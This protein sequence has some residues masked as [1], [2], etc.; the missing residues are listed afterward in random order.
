LLDAILINAIGAF[1]NTQNDQA[2]CLKFNE[3]P[4]YIRIVL[5]ISSASIFTLLRAGTDIQFE[6]LPPEGEGRRLLSSEFGLLS[7]R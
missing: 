7:S 1:R 3:R 5:F 2:A 6:V 4:N